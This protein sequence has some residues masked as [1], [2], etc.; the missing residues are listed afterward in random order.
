MK[1][2]SNRSRR[3]VLKLGA[4]VATASLAGCTRLQEETHNTSQ[5]S[6]HDSG[7][8]NVSEKENNL[9]EDKETEY[10]EL[11]LNGVANYIESE[12]K[13]NGYHSPETEGM[14]AVRYGDSGKADTV[15]FN[16]D[17]NSLL[18]QSDLEDQ[19]LGKDQDIFKIAATDNLDTLHD[20]IA[21]EFGYMEETLMNQMGVFLDDYALPA[22][23]EH[24]DI[25]IE[26]VGG[27]SSIVSMWVRKEQGEELEKRFSEEDLEKRWYET[28]EDTSLPGLSH[29]PDHYSKLGYIAEGEQAPIDVG[30][31][32][33]NI[34]V[35]HIDGE[36]AVLGIGDEVFE[37]R[38]GEPVIGHQTGIYLEDTNPFYMERGAEFRVEGEDVNYDLQSDQS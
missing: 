19:N 35:R 20:D 7:S 17:V 34:Q 4:A 37:V 28:G 22:D 1:E 13:N 14:S 11:H 26:L 29:R 32:R 3:E 6:E 23:S 31:R 18:E 38:A 36:D 33:Y 15:T 8:K 12:L 27:E 30:D 5:D 9:S 24:L 21:D 16:V 25:S 10:N 2:D